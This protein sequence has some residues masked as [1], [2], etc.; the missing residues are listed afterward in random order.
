MEDIE[1]CSTI[2]L[3]FFHWARSDDRTDRCWHCMT[4]SDDGGVPYL[5]CYLLKLA[6]SIVDELIR[7]I[8]HALE[9]GA[10]WY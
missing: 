7:R 2:E 5:S 3:Y 4:K 6:V 9:G 10:L 8:Y 1:T